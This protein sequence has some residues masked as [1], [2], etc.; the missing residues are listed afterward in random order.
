MNSFTFVVLLVRSLFPPFY[1]SAAKFRTTEL[2]SRITK[3][4]IFVPALHFFCYQ[5][6]E[7]EYTSFFTVSFLSMN[8]IGASH[9]AILV[10]LYNALLWLA[11]GCQVCS[12][13]PVLFRHDVPRGKH[14]LL[15]LTLTKGI[16]Q[17]NA[18]VTVATLGA[19]IARAASHHSHLARHRFHTE[20]DEVPSLPED[21]ASKG[22]TESKSDKSQKNMTSTAMISVLG[23][24]KN[25]ISPLL[26]PACRFVPT[27]SQYGVQAIERFGP[28]KGVILIA[29]RLLR[30]S[31]IGGK[32]YDPPKWP[33]VPFTYS[34]Y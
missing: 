8:N 29:W 30:C 22:A 34:S 32:G 6:C 17:K 1:Y 28:E 20:S 31:P 27:C 10:M 12:P 23:V 7:Q 26:P 33:P 18:F 9:L 25:F 2:Q 15:G 24:Y 16:M 19:V 13:W 3:Q 14:A 4:M 21:D 11:E 5:H